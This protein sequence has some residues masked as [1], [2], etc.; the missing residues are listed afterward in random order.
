[1]MFHYI[2]YADT[3]V[4]TRNRQREGDREHQ[5]QTERQRVGDKQ[6]E[7]GREDSDG[8]EHRETEQV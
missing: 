8:S 6:T 4:R 2:D 7:T 3:T 1:M 5:K